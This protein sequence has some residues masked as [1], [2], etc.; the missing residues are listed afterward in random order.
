[1]ANQP[2]KMTKTGK[3]TVVVGLGDLPCHVCVKPGLTWI[4]SWSRTLEWGW[5]DSLYESI[6]G[7]VLCGG[8]NRKCSQGRG[9]VS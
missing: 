2:E 1:M 8:T 6:V 3:E 4:F 5:K 7:R 9:R